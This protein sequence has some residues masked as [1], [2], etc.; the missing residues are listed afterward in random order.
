[1][2]KKKRR[3]RRPEDDSV[4][5]RGSGRVY[6]ERYKDK[7]GKWKACKTWSYEYSVGGKQQRVHTGLLD[8]AQAEQQRREKL[9]DLGRGLPPGI[10]AERTTYEDMKEVIREDYVLKDQSLY[11]L[12]R[13]LRKL[14]KDFAG[15]RALTITR[16][17]L[18]SRTARRKREGAAVATINI[19]NAV[20]NR[21]FTLSVKSKMLI[22]EHHPQIEK[23]EEHNQ[24]T[25]VITPA[26]MNEFL[27]LFDDP[28]V[29]DAVEVTFITGWRADSDVL[30]RRREHVRLLEHAFVLHDGEGK[31]KRPRAF[32]IH[33]GGRLEEIL[34]RRLRD[35]P[36]GCPWV[37]YWTGRQYHGQRMSDYR[38]HWKRAKA[39]L[40]KLHP[41][42]EV[43]TWVRHRMR[44]SAIMMY[45]SIGTIPSD[46]ICKM[47]GLTP[48]ML[49]RY[50]HLTE[51]NM[52][53]AGAAIEQ[54][55]RNRGMAEAAP[56][57]AVLPFERRP[58]TER[59]A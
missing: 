22:A 14:D 47:V 19:E 44:Y 51:N 15:N 21:M 36:E 7:G 55:L 39:E 59:K 49:A 53:I 24:R 40:A 27:R 42:W 57:H 3:R 46:Q 2:N 16:S 5:P 9:A 28:N 23:L 41:D 52:A 6:H 11:H 12:E 1:V 58:A 50:H 18:I 25:G 37:F 35:A 56:D 8:K 17:R 34:T 33:P 29:R 32:P 48:M 4:G 13:T 43:E 30:T 54:T 38:N 26:Q 10:G 45:L 20:V 31:A